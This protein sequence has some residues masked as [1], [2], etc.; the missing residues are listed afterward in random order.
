MKTIHSSTVTGLAVFTLA[1]LN[2]AQA[3]PGR[4]GRLRSSENAD[5]ADSKISGSPRQDSATAASQNAPAANCGRYRLIDLGTLG[6]PTSSN[7]F[8][9]RNI[10]DN[11][12]QVIAFADTAVA[13]PNCYLRL[14]LLARHPAWQRNG[15]IIELPFR[16]GSIRQTTPASRAI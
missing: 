6:G 2:T 5:L 9:A 14:L 16:R 12:G 4:F 13:D 3:Q 15:N 8:P 7:V 10:K 11:R 1:I